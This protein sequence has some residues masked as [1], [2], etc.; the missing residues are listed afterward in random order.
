MVPVIHKY[1]IKQIM[2]NPILRFHMMIWK[3]GTWYSV[4]PEKQN[5]LQDVDEVTVD[6][7]VI[8]CL[9]VGMCIL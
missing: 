6:Y 1:K 8:S 2:N 5:Q 7:T 3:G 4:L 9:Y